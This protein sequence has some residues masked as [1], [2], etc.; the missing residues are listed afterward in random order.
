[1]RLNNLQQ[2]HKYLVRYESHSKNDPSC[3]IAIARLAKLRN[4]D[5]KLFTQM[6]RAFED[7]LLLMP[8]DLVPSYLRVLAQQKNI[9]AEETLLAQFLER[10]PNSKTIA[11]YQAEKLYQAHQWQELVDGLEKYI[12]ISERAM[13]LYTFA[14][15]RLNK[16]KQAQEVFN[17]LP[18]SNSFNYWKLAA[19]IAEVNND[20]LMLKTCLE[21]QLNS[22]S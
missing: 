5:E 4:D 9:V 1:M 20:K 15:C 12:Q 18:K 21:N 6:N 8:E 17:A 11:L 7:N 2:A 14:L 22:I 3:R 19:E 10:Y 13:Y 16:S